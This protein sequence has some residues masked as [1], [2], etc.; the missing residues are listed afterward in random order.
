[1]QISKLL[2]QILI[3]TKFSKSS[4]KSWFVALL[5]QTMTGKGGEGNGSRKTA[6]LHTKSEVNFPD[7]L[8]A[9][10][11]WGLWSGVRVDWV[12][13]S[14]GGLCGLVRW[15]TAENSE[16]GCGRVEGVQVPGC[17]NQQQTEPDGQHQRYV[18]EGDYSSL[19]L[20]TFIVRSKMLAV[21]HR[22]VEAGALFFWQR[23][24]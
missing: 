10:A 3:S 24:T 1:M 7:A 11:L 22:C 4:F 19:S 2:F 21:F 12:E 15:S 18:Q 8:L 9:E 6:R 17:L 23:Q 16:R 13:A 20:P 5:D 14:N